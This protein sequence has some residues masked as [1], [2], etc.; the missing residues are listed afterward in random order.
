MTSMSIAR[1]NLQTNFPEAGLMKV[2]DIETL[3]SV[4]TTL[5]TCIG[6]RR[7]LCV[8]LVPGV[9]FFDERRFHNSQQS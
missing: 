2:D 3:L 9:A 8:V 1:A 5:S 4:R 6:L 7:R